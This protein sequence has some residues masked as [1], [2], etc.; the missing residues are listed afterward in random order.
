MESQAAG[1]HPWEVP[2]HPLSSDVDGFRAASSTACEVCAGSRQ[3]WSELQC[4]R[5]SEQ[6]WEKMRLS[7]EGSSYLFE[8]L[9]GWPKRSL[10][11]FCKMLP[12]NKFLANS[13]LT[14]VSD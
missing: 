11:F 6:G 2:R 13:I 10:G 4:P 12:T 3:L 8:H 7:S 1:W 14:Q 5:P 9:L